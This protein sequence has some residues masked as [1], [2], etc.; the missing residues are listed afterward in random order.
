MRERCEF[1]RVKLPQLPS[2]AD[3]AAAL[4][5][6][7]EAARVQGGGGKNGWPSEDLYAAFRDAAKELRD[8]IDKVADQT[9]FDPAAAL[10]AAEAALGLLAVTHGL[11]DAFQKRK[12]ELAALDF[13]DLLIR[14]R[15]LV[16][17]EARADLRKHLAAQTQLLLVDEFQD[18]DPLQVELVRALC[19]GRVADGKLF[20]VGDYKQSIYRF[21]GADPRVFRSLR[22]EIPAQGRLPLT[23]N[24]RSQPAVIEFVNALFCR[25]MGPEYEALATRR[26]QLG[27]RPA[28]EFLWAIEPEA[29]TGSL[30]SPSGRGAG[31]GTDDADEEGPTAERTRR[32]EA[33]WIARRLRGMLDKG[34]KL[35]WD[36]SAGGAGEPAFAPFAPATSRSCSG[37]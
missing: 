32:R 33:E 18:T 34:E 12:T 27:P 13:D 26:P 10:P 29:V 31:E 21:R 6:I 4:E 8:T 25:E 35:V 16:A 7:R 15:D 5:E 30:P 24:F 9:A 22:D 23:L 36:Q 2:A 20:F 19:D 11:A 3:P 37:H 17:P 14:A 28:V 1:L